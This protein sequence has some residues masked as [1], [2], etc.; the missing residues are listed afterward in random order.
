MANRPGS[1]G[2]YCEH[3]RRL[4]PAA[5]AVREASPAQSG[6]ATLRIASRAVS[7][8]SRHLLM[9]Y[10][11][12]FTTPG[13]DASAVSIIRER[14]LQPVRHSRFTNCTLDV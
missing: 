5:K 2:V 10:G 3:A 11:T 6:R 12:H 4:Q 9:C 13:N 14:R 8:P 7:D 1:W